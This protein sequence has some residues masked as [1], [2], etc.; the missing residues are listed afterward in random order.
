[1]ANQV[2]EIDYQQLAWFKQE[3]EQDARDLKRL[4]FDDLKTQSEKTRDGIKLLMPVDTG[5]AQASWGSAP[6]GPIAAAKGLD[7]VWNESF[8]T[9]T[10]E[11]GSERDAYN[12]IIRLNEGYS[13]QAAAR[14]IDTEAEKGILD[15]EKRLLDRLEKELS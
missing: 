8:D 7:G 11:Q 9:L 3:L 4:L 5:A 13:Q 1:M 12:Y 14:F 15:L 2:F 10:I 6:A